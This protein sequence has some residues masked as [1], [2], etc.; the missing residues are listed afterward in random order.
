MNPPLINPIL[1]P[2]HPPLFL[3]KIKLALG[4]VMGHVIS[5]M[6]FSY[7]LSE[8]IAK[9]MNVVGNRLSYHHSAMPSNDS[10]KPRL[11]PLTTP[12]LTVETKDGNDAK[13][14]E[15]T[16]DDECVPFDDEEPSILSSHDIN[17]EIANEP[18]KTET[19]KPV[20]P[21]VH[22]IEKKTAPPQAKII[23]VPDDG[24]CLLYAMGIGIRKKYAA[25]P[26]IQAKL[27]WEVDVKHLS[28][29]LH[30]A[31]D[32][33][34][35]P[36]KQLRRQASQYLEQH[37]TNDEITLSLIEGISSHLDVAKRKLR[38]EED[39]VPILMM[40]IEKL[41]D[42]TQTPIVKN[43]LVE[44]RKHLEIVQDSI[45]YQKAN[46]PAE[47]DFQGYID[48]TKK[49]RVYCGVAQL[50]ALSKYYGIPVSVLYNYGKAS[51]HE[52]IFNAEVN[53]GRSDP[54]PILTIAHV[55]GNHFQ[56]VND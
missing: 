18:L 8:L 6:I 5:T 54:L 48:I 31:K 23:D 29:N 35:F 40:D 22:V 34:E 50:F 45:C 52:Q 46:M 33:L 43:Q 9:I 30:K 19:K 49:D 44:K 41:Q 27:Q 10:L 21:I 42:K 28:V 1:P 17:H 13:D 12:P 4:H 39:L 14:I 51:Q 3:Q 47:A 25:Y 55:N 36:G 32:L 24:N 11:S 56:Y 2:P 26:E 38:E 16:D 20:S 15:N 37:K 53:T 7:V